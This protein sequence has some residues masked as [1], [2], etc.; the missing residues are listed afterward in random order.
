MHM[1]VQ[2]AIFIAWQKY[3][4]FKKNFKK[5]SFGLFLQ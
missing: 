2:G 3:L 5:T 1:I 4:F